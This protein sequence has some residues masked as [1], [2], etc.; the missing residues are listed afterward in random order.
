MQQEDEQLLELFDKEFKAAII[1]YGSEP[2]RTY[3]KQVKQ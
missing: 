3:L 2:L 1:K